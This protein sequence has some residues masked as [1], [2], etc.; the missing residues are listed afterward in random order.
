[1]PSRSGQLSWRRIEIMGIIELLAWVHGRSGSLASLAQADVDEWLAG[2]PRPFLHHFLTWAGR[3]GSS[4]QLA[5]PRPSSGGLN[6]QALS[7]DERWRLFADVTSDASIDPH[8]KFAAGLML[9]FGV[10]AAKIVQLRAEGVAVTDQ[11]VIVRLGTEPLVLP[12]EL[13]PAAAGAAS[14]R[15]ATRMF[16]ESIE[17]EWVYPGARAGRHRRRVREEVRRR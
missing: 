8:T 12:A 13:A 10:R 11:A 14:N 7:D 5:A 15:T 1:M 17:Q 9:M 16:V 6:P 3:D 4:R 2:G